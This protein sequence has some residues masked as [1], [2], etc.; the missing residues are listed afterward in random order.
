MLETK[1]ANR[2]SKLAARSNKLFGQLDSIARQTEFIERFSSK[3]SAAGFVLSLLKAV[4]T[5]RGSFNQLAI[6]LGLSEHHKMSRQG[7]WKRVTEK[8]VAFMMKCT[9]QAVQD[10]WNEDPV[11]P[12]DK[13][14]RVLVEDSS[15]GKVDKRNAEDFPAHGNGHGQ[16]AGCKI[17]LSFDLLTGE[18]LCPSLHL[19]TTQDREIGKDLVGEVG[20]NDLVLRDM[21][22]FSLAEFAEIASRDAFW[23]SRL[24]INVLAHDAE[25][26]KLETLLRKTKGKQIDDEMFIGAERF[27]VRLVAIRAEPG[28]ARERRRIRRQEARKLGKQPSKDALTRDGWH[29]LITN[30]APD[31]LNTRELADL[32]AARWQIEITF[33]AWKQSGELVKSLSRRSNASHLQCLMYAA[34]LQLILTLKVA[35]LL[36]LRYRGSYDLSIERIAHDLTSFLLTLRHLEAFSLYDPDPRHIKMDVRSRKSL[37]HITAECLG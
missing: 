2:G 7:F 30:V 28:I 29:I 1:R 24:P 8:A 9:H 33:R 22:Y 34:I 14:A 20:D 21:G 4:Q 25:G 10:R 17:D 6:T 19:A 11:V 27:P 36:R 32:Y 23:L 13:F 12:T 26:R 31:T 35:S 16:T 15:Q 3:F 18:P 37:T 5:G